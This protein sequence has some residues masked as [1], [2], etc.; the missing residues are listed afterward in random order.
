MKR[1]L[2]IIATFTLTA[3][4]GFSANPV[5]T[6][7]EAM[8]FLTGN[9]TKP[10]SK[11]LKEF[12]LAQVA[13]N[14]SNRTFA[15]NLPPFRK[16]VDELTRQV[17]KFEKEAVAAELDRRNSMVESYRTKSGAAKFL[18]DPEK[19]KA[20]ENAEAKL[21]TAKKSL[22]ELKAAESNVVRDKINLLTQVSAENVSMELQNKALVSALTSDALLMDFAKYKDI[23][24]DVDLALEKISGIYDKTVLG[25]Y[26]KDKMGLL[27]NSQVMCE[28]AAR[29]R[30]PER[31]EISSDRIQQALFP[32]TEDSSRKGN[33]YDKTHGNS[34]AQ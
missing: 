8:N 14:V 28:A 21:A 27:L 24:G 1:I 4:L 15:A 26:L 7:Q 34:G 23:L 2:G 12:E 13:V 3:S 16:Q 20:V 6:E 5:L 17:E 31:K 33:L 9:A 29:C 30:V 10:A 25:A 32:G 19:I 11:T 18:K 22:A